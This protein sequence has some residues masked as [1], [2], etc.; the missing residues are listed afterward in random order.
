[1]HFLFL[2][3]TSKDTSPGYF[4]IEM[5]SSVPDEKCDGIK[6]YGQQLTVNNL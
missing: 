5:Q 1:M 2:W 4:D 3:E 6:V